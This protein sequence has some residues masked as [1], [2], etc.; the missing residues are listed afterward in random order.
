MTK[1]HPSSSRMHSSDLVKIAHPEI[2]HSSLTFHPNQASFAYRRA[3]FHPSTPNLLP[4]QGKVKKN[5]PCAR[6]SFAFFPTSL[7]F[8]H[9]QKSSLCLLRSTTDYR[10]FLHFSLCGTPHRFLVYCSSFLRHFFVVFILN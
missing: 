8:P 5:S 2:K 3:K 10:E 6:G 1:V 9:D 7:I 4:D